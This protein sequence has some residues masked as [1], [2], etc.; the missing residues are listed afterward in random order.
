MFTRLVTKLQQRIIFSS[1]IQQPSSSYILVPYTQIS[2]ASFSLLGSRRSIKPGNRGD[3]SS[4]QG[5]TTLVK[6]SS[7]YSTR[8]YFSS[9]LMKSPPINHNGH[10]NRYLHT[11]DQTNHTNNNNGKKGLP[12][13]VKIV[14]VGPRD[15]LQAEPVLIP[16]PVKINFIN[17]LSQ[18][19]YVYFGA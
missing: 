10:Q 12:S 13:F 11:K 2:A 14:E 6:D 19:G 3:R 16:T 15:G 9:I 8:S 4:R 7:N 1:L 17:L 5:G 18:S